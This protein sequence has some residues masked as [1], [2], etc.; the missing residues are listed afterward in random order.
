MIEP[1]SGIKAFY[2]YGRTTELVP[3]KVENIARQ[4]SS[5]FVSA[6][7]SSVPSY[8]ENAGNHSCTCSHLTTELGDDGFRTTVIEVITVIT[9]RRYRLED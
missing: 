1:R 9:R 3:V 6:R 8:G 2:T 4:S 7:D 5:S